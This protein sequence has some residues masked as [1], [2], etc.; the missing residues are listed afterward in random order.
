MQ[1]TIEELLS[2]SEALSSAPQIA[3][4]INGLLRGPC[5]LDQ[6]VEVV[7][8]D[9]NISARILHACAA[10]SFGERSTVSSLSEAFARL[11]RAHIGRIVW[12]VTLSQRMAASLPIYGMD[13]GELWRH[14]MT[15][16]IAG[17]EIWKISK[18]NEDI[19]CAFTACLLHDIGKILI[20]VSLYPDATVFREFVENQ[21][22]VTH[23]AENTLLGYDHAQVGGRLLA[24]WNQTKEMI[25]AVLFHH[26]PL[27]APE[28][29]LPTLI[30]LAD[31]CAHHLHWKRE[32]SIRES[33]LVVAD[34][35]LDVLEIN[36]A[37]FSRTLDTIVSRASEVEV[38][39]AIT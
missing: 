30:F 38:L 14:S 36:H 32:K 10:V 12:Q 4:K 11:G 5:Y 27:E 8:Y 15:S 22:L 25:S 2:K 29:R 26:N 28:K 7:Q 18:L 33:Q 37:K 24:G 17:E 3:C 21:M 1:T 16:A 13:A 35:Y 20:D 6:L 19:D 39:M 31:L 23:E 9:P 34:V